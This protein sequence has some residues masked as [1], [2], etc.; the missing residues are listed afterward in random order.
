MSESVTP[1]L[2]PGDRFI[3]RDEVQRLTGL[4]RSSIYARNQH[5]PDWPKPISLGPN[6]VAWI[7]SEVL[8]WASR[9]IARARRTA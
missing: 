6:T 4:S 5:D 9:Q 1:A 3:R 7:E 2:K 8:A